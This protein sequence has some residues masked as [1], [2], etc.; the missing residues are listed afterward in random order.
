M[1][2]TRP[3]SINFGVGVKRALVLARSKP[4]TAAPR[5]IEAL[6][7][8]SQMPTGPE[9]RVAANHKAMHSNAR[10][11]LLG[12]IS[13]GFFVGGLSEESVIGDTCSGP[14]SFDDAPGASD[15]SVAA[16]CLERA[17][18]RLR[19]GQASRVIDEGPEVIALGQEILG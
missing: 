12:A 17:P 19:K 16:L 8:A 3:T 5:A 11:A 6:P 14:R 7:T 2:A 4:N 13:S 10:E 18:R 9:K 15:G 1:P